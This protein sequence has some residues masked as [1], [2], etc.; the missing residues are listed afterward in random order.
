[1]QLFNSIFFL[2]AI[3]IT[4]DPRGQTGDVNGI[5]EFSEYNFTTS[6]MNMHH[7]SLITLEVQSQEQQ[8][9]QQQLGVD[10]MCKFSDKKTIRKCTFKLRKNFFFQTLILTRSMAARPP[11]SGL[12]MKVR[13]W[14]QALFTSLDEFL[15]TIFTLV[16]DENRQQQQQQQKQQ[17]PQQESHPK[18]EL[19]FNRIYQ[20]FYLSFTLFSI[21]FNRSSQWAKE[22]SKK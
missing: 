20:S 13:S 1:M 2:V 16:R 18:S 6:F 17:Q 10:Q 22:I 21:Y 11:P 4:P 9:Q 8:Q 7:F 15:Y 3:E 12:S 14:I 5:K 19:L